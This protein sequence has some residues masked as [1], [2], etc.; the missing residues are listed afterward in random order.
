[1]KELKYA[2]FL[3]NTNEAENPLP[4][5]MFMYDMNNWFPV[6]NAVVWGRVFPVKTLYW[7]LK[8]AESLSLPPS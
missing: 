1:M 7:L 2:T 4:N 6:D 3:P 5:P 8:C